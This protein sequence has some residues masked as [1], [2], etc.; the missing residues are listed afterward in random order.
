MQAQVPIPEDYL[1]AGRVG[2]YVQAASSFLKNSP[3]DRFAPRV[4]FDLYTLFSSMGKTK[5]AEQLRGKLLLDYPLSFQAG[6]LI[7]TF[8]DASKFSDKSRW[9]RNRFNP[10]LYSR[11]KLLGD[12]KSVV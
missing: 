12:R 6:Y 3:T 8:E 1:P 2:E 10:T 11:Q 5:E 4:T 7:T 9:P